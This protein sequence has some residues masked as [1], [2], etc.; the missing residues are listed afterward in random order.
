MLAST[1]Q[2]SRNGRQR[3]RTGTTA[4][5]GA[6]P[7]RGRAQHPLPQD[8]TACPPGPAPRAP[9]PRPASGSVLTGPRTTGKTR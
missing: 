8:P 9:V 2:F 1:V 5:D 3:P 4:P 6:A 7:V